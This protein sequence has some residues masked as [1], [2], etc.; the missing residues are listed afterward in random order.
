[1]YSVGGMYPSIPTLYF[2]NSRGT[3]PHARD[4]EGVLA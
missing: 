2:Q 1:V 4:S 3:N